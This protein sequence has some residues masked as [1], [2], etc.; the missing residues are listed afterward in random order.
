MYKILVI[1]DEKPLRDTIE[2]ILRLNNFK[3]KTVASGEEGL[4]VLPIFLPD[5]I[6]CDIMM[7]GISGIELLAKIRKDVN[8]GYIPFIFLSAKNKSE[9]LRAGMNIGADDYLTKPFRA[10]DLLKAIEIRLKQYNTVY[11]AHLE[12]MGAIR[13]SFDRYSF[14]ELNTP[15]SAIL[16]G[17]DFLIQYEGEIFERERQEMMGVILKSSKRIQRTIKNLMFY[18]REDSLD[19]FK[20]PATKCAV[21]YSLTQVKDRLAHFYDVGRIKVS[22]QPQMLSIHADA[23]TFV[24]LEIIDNAL[25]FSSEEKSVNVVGKL[26]D[27]QYHLQIIDE[28]IGMDSDEI[29]RIEPFKQFKRDIREQQGFGLGLYLSQ[30]VLEASGVELRLLSSPKNGTTVSLVFF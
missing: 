28:G 21:E 6:V 26:I 24:L 12:K 29:T 18:L 17:L 8:Y 20:N 10:A 11:E 2:E 3:V 15:L 30:K 23:L 4:Q 7:P 9:D 22:I 25:K 13:R 1:D 5:L 19:R 14:H 27:E 16:G